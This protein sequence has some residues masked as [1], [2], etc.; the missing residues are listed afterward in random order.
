MDHINNKFRLLPFAL[1]LLLTVSSCRSNNIASLPPPDKQCRSGSGWHGLFPGKSTQDDTVREL[2]EPLEKGRLKFDD[3]YRSYYAYK[4]DHGKV[5]DYVHDRIF[6]RP[7]G[8]IDWM[9][10]VEADRS[11]KFE[12]VYSTVLQLGKQIDIVYTN[13]NYRPWITGGVG[14][15]SAGPDQIYVW[16]E[17]GLLLD[18]LGSKYSS[19]FQSKDLQCK[20]DRDSACTLIVRNP[21]PA[22]L[23]EGEPAADI[24][25]VVLMKIYFQPTVYSAFT[26]YYMYKMPY[27]LWY[28]YLPDNK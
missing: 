18:A 24:N 11:G 15:I 25:S 16:S 14:D 21:A 27:G 22:Y 28:K 3:Q 19:N 13:S 2:G 9:E 8:V 1:I 7:D 23:G 26:Q 6:F 17:C 5:A 10:I 4:V 12:T 20:S